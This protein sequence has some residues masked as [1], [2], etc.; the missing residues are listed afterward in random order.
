MLTECSLASSGS[1]PKTS[2]ETWCQFES[3]FVYNNRRALRPAV[4][5]IDKTE[6]RSQVYILQAT[7]FNGQP[8]I[9]QHSFESYAAL[10]PVVHCICSALYV[11]EGHY[12]V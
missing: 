6:L 10:I 11:C 1:L 4:R 12:F 9:S 7:L 8:L 2:L 5:T 3:L